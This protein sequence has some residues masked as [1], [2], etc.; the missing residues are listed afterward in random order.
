MF[1]GICGTGGD[2][3]GLLGLSFPSAEWGVDCA[4]SEDTRTITFFQ[5]ILLQTL[6]TCAVGYGAVSLI[7]SWTAGDFVF[8]TEKQLCEVGEM[9]TSRT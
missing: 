1:R 5:I 9:K 8:P 3:K 6:P 2:H 7:Q 4:T